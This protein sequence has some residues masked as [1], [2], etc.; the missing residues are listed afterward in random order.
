MVFSGIEHLL[1][2]PQYKGGIGVRRRCT[3]DDL[4]CTCRDV[5][6]SPCSFG[7]RT[8]AFEHDID[9]MLLPWDLRRIAVIHDVDPVGPEREVI[10]SI[11]HRKRGFAMD[12]I[13][14]DQVRKVLDGCRRIRGR[15]PDIPC[16]V[17]CVMPEHE[18]PDPSQAVYR[19][20]LDDHSLLPVTGVITLPPASYQLLFES[21][22]ETNFEIFLIYS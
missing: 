15:K 20:R 14:G 9:A 21:V 1:V 4:C 11:R 3:D 22:Y 13:V 5:A 12:R 10:F 18:P 19:N 16:R 6:G 8:G 2:D 17:F 7:E